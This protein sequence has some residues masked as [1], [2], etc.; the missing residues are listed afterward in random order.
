[1]KKNAEIAK[2]RVDRMNRL[3]I[4]TRDFSR[5]SEN[6]QRKI[7][8][9]EARKSLSMLKSRDNYKNTLKK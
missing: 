1:M 6:F 5:M 7:D 4:E 8:E 2:R 9:F 3:E